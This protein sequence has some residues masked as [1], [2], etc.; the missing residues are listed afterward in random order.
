MLLAAICRFHPVLEASWFD[1]ELRPHRWAKGIRV[2][3]ILVLTARTAADC[4]MYDF[5]INVIG[6]PLLTF[7][8]LGVSSLR[9]KQRQLQE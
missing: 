4:Q 3:T 1:A 7:S 5:Y 8:I 6:S 9:L 2:L